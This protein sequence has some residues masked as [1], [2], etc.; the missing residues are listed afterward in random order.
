MW[1]LVSERIASNF[2]E[3]R[4]MGVHHYLAQATAGFEVQPL[5]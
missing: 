2:L 5:V 4:N 3:S 1:H